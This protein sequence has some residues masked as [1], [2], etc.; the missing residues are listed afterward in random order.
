MRFDGSLRDNNS[1]TDLLD[2]QLILN[3]Y[4]NDDNGKIFFGNWWYLKI[5]QEIQVAQQILLVQV[6]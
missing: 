3:G 4:Y 1:G 2:Q 6:L 5:L